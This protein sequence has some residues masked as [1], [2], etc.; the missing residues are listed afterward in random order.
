[1]S[2]NFK[3]I[4]P[5]KDLIKSPKD[6]L[7]IKKAAEINNRVLDLVADFIKEG[8]STEEINTIGRFPELISV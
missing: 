1:M 4:A 6:I 5:P 7:G 2:K 8:V 3:M